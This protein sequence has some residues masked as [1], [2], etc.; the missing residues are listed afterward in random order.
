MITWVE[1]GGGPL[2][3][4][5]ETSLRDWRG[6]DPDDLDDEDD[7]ARACAV[8]GFA[9]VV[10]VGQEGAQALVLGDD[11]ATTCYMPEMRAFIRWNAAHNADS[12][13]SAAR[14]LVADPIAEWDDCGV[15]E[16]DG[17]AVLMDAG[18]DGAQPWFG[19]LVP[20]T[21][22]AGRWKILAAMHEYPHTWVTVVRL[23]PHEQ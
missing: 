12:L 13:I 4:V 14:A 2:V 3:V 20:V 23:L 19:T 8:D 7:A 18:E 10:A 16:T 5:P 17:P 22:G 21:I 9:G 15:W 6:V 11:P 1:S